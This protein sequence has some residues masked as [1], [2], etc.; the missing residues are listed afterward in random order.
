MLGDS[1]LEKVT[2][3]VKK[4]RVVAPAEVSTEEVMMVA[5]AGGSFDFLYDPGEDTYNLTQFKRLY[6][7]VSGEMI[8]NP[9]FKPTTE[10]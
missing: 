3:Y 1:D 6:D 7:S 9:A 2:N 10:K 8:D 4:L 5:E